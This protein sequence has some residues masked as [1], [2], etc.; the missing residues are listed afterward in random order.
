MAESIELVMI[1]IL[2]LIF[3][4]LCQSQSD[5]GGAAI[6][7]LIVVRFNKIVRATSVILWFVLIVTPEL[8]EYRFVF[9]LLNLQQVSVVY[10][11][12]SRHVV[13]CAE[14]KRRA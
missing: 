1:M 6:Q 12:R 8:K 10:L 9:M 2:L 11:A 14:N 7:H 5:R 13:K 3:N 4:L